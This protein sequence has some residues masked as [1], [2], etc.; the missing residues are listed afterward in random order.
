EAHGKD[1]QGGGHGHGAEIPGLGEQDL[2]RRLLCGHLK[3]REECPDE[4]A[5]NHRQEWPAADTFPPAPCD[6]EH[7]RNDCG[8]EPERRSIGSESKVHAHV[9]VTNHTTNAPYLRILTLCRRERSMTFAEK[10]QGIINKGV[11]ATRDLASKAGEKAKDLGAMGMVKVEIMQLE[12]HAEKIIARL[13]N[14][15]YRA[16]VEKKGSSVSKDSPLISDML[17]EIEGL[18]ARIEAKEKEY[19]AIG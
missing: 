2:G 15:V 4:D 5:S 1:E 19:H 3:C 12:S 18:R 7:E 10:M 11:A 9:S 13:G 8:G 14:E 16:L 6:N 17:K